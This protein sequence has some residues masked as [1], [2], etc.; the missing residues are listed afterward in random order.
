[1][2][3]SLILA[4]IFAA[5]LAAFQ[6]ADAQERERRLNTVTV[7]ALGPDKG[8]LHINPIVLRPQDFQRPGYSELE[9]VFV[10]VALIEDRLE[11]MLGEEN[12]D[13]L[14]LI[15]EIPARAEGVDFKDSAR[16]YFTQSVILPRGYYVLSE[17]T[18]RRPASGA[19]PDTRTVSHCLAD[20]SILLHIKG[21]DVIYMGRPEFNY[22]S[23]ARLAD[24]SF[25]P[26][27]RMLSQIDRLRGWRDT[28]TDLERFEVSA[29]KF[30][31]TTAFCSPQATTPV[32]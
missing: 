15:T 8:E 21:G 27:Q 11:P 23:Y 2:R 32:M 25:S 10:P 24:P 7:T 17:V 26:A 4:V 13:Y 9:L 14:R 5:L 28:A 16:D 22:P 29:A 1:M 20:Q 30:K 18:F 31:R 12:R 3:A 19:Q 6:I